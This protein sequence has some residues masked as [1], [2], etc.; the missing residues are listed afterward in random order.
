MDNSRLKFRAWDGSDM[1]YEKFSEYFSGFG[2]YFE[3]FES[4]PE[5]MQFTGL[6]DSKG[7][8]IYEGDILSTDQNNYL[9]TTGFTRGGFVAMSPQDKYDFVFLDDYNFEI[10]GNIY[11]NGDLIK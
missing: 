11:Q 4:I 8:D 10:I 7:I 6:K 5:V 3:Q 2:C 9:W 1:Q